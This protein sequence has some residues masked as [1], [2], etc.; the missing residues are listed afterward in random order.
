MLL[1]GALYKVE[2]DARATG[3]AGE[4]YYAKRLAMRQE[5]SRASMTKLKTRLDEELSEHRPKSPFGVAI[6]YARSQ[7]PSR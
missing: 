6:A 2:A 7:W 3:L 1:I 4:D 5:G